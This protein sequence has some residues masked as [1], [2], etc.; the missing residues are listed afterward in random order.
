MLTHPLPM[1]S[2]L[3]PD[4]Q[5]PRSETSAVLTAAQKHR[6]YTLVVPREHG[7]WGMLLAPLVTGAAVG[8][9]IG[10]RVAQVLLLATTVLLLFWLR[11]P[12]ESWLGTGVMR[13]QS[14][15]ERKFVWRV[16]L[17]LAT[18]VALTL[19][20][21]FWRGKNLELLWI[22]AI[23]SVA[24]LAQLAL[25]KMGRSTRMAAQIVGSV[26]LTSTAPAAYYVATGKVDAACGAL[27]LTNWLFA[28]DQI[29]FVWL[30]IRGAHAADLKARIATGWSFLAGNVAL[31]GGLTLASYLGLLPALALIAFVPA[32]LRGLAW[33]ARKPRP[34][35]VRQ[36]GFSELAHALVF[37]ALLIAAFRF[38]R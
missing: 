25:R 14:Q 4:L 20:A 23:A 32:M 12:V 5:T 26:A 8:L 7:A 35:V 17:S 15:R 36:L 31:I 18:L 2:S 27:W 33:F 34:L 37:C 13:A 1:D 3:Q 19:S 9:P 29:H 24:F 22:G 38:A 6:R 30:R 21:L 11:T 28:S 10:G 16:I